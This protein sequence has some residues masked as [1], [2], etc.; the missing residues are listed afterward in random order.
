MI[1]FF[2][3]IQILMI[4][5]F[6]TSRNQNSSFHNKFKSNKARITVQEKFSTTLKIKSK[7]KEIH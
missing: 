5:T 2:P 4:P 7:V 6:L 3:Y 1:L